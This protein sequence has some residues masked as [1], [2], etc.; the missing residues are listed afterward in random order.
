[1]R[2]FRWF[3]GLAAAA[4]LSLAAMVLT[5]LAAEVDLRAPLRDLEAFAGSAT[6]GGLR[7]REVAR[8][9]ARPP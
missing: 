7:S 3:V 8:P 9:I 5:A 2:L 1:M 4:A 6:V